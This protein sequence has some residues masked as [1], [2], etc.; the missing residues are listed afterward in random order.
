MVRGCI[1][2]WKRAAATDPLSRVCCPTAEFWI[3]ISN[4]PGTLSMSN[5][6]QRCSGGSQLLMKV[7]H[8][9]FLDWFS[10]GDSM[11]PVFGRAK[12]EASMDLMIDISKVST[13]AD[14]YPRTPILM[15]SVTIRMP[16]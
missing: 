5:T 14:D 7:V 16:E 1:R 10:A 3:K 6:G 9:D 8:N 2:V 4:E 12:D 11:H 13:T 15:K